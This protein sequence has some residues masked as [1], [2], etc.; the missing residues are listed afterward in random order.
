MLDQGTDEW[1]Q[2]RL[3]KVTASRMSDVMAQGRGGQ[4]SATRATYMG[5]LVAERLTGVPMEGFTSAAME[6]G[7]DT[8]AQARAQY[9]L[10]SGVDVEQVGFV[11]HPELDDAGASPD[12]MVGSNGLIEIKCPNTAT[13]IKT[14]RGAK[15]DRKY[16]LQMQWQMLC[17]QRDW[18][19]FVS[20][21]PRLPDY[22]AMHIQRVTL[23]KELAADM[24][25]AVIS[26]ILELQNTEL[27][28]RAMEAA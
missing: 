12:G 11:L 7:T 17:T 16:M 21:D 22:C 9:E 24:E 3:G 15:I 13:H 5:Q 18:C 2:A 4:P 23:D 25:A 1:L 10:R 6:H 8:E 28:L 20:F 14:L 19:D 26:F 27:E